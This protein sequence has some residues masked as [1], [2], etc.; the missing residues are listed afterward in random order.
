MKNLLHLACPVGGY[1]VV[2]DLEARVYDLADPMG[3]YPI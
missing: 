3:C 1:A 2:V